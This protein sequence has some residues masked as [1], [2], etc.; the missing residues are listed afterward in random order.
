MQVIWLGPHLLQLWITRWPCL[1]LSEPQR[2]AMVARNTSST[3]WNL[4][5]LPS[6]LR[7]TAPGHY[8]PGSRTA[9]KAV[10]SLPWG[11]DW[12]REYGGLLLES[13]LPINYAGPVGKSYHS[14]SYLYD[15][16]HT[17]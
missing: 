1:F 11:H 3:C 12:V 8:I 10:L 13:M 14:F 4:F 17:F 16:E 15:G 6:D 5:K 9:N 7:A 2:D